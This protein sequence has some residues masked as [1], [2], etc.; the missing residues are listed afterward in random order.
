M[1]PVISP[2][3]VNDA[4]KAQAKDYKLTSFDY[5]M[6]DMIEEEADRHRVI[7]HLTL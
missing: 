2:F 6:E 1:K 4:F 3:Q 7:R 5:D